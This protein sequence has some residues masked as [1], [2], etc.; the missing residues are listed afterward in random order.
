MQSD[1]VGRKAAVE[2]GPAAFASPEQIPAL[3]SL[4]LTAFPEDQPVEIARFFQTV[5]RPECCLVSTVDGRPASMAFLLPAVLETGSGA[6]S[7]QYIYAAATLPDFRGQGM[8]GRLLRR[9]QELGRDQGLVASFLRPAGAGLAQYYERFGYRPFFRAVDERI[10]VD[11]SGEPVSLRPVSPA[12]YA[13]LRGGALSGTTAWVRWPEELT[14]YAA[15]SARR[16]GGEVI[17]AGGGC[18]LCEPQGTTL[19]IREWLPAPGIQGE[20]ALRRAVSSRFPL[21]EWTRRRPAREGETAAPFGWLCPLT[22][23]AARVFDRLRDRNPYMGLAF[24]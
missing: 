9:A 7:L 2:D 14:A 5:F 24:D 20:R 4:W 3:T 6:F 12:R 23:D 11:P 8:F 16:V 17:G 18:A 21:S 10:F 19:F 15:E 13:S 22:E 1:P